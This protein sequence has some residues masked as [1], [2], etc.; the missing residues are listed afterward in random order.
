ML[1]KLDS[2]FHILFFKYK[3]IS[4]SWGISEK[5]DFLSLLNYYDN[6]CIEFNTN[7]DIES[8]DLIYDSENLYT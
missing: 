2:N 5:I 6:G 8:I 7:I 4:V 3:D 1:L